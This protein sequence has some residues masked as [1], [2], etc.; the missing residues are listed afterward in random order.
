MSDPSK[1]PP[2]AVANRLERSASPYLRQH[3]F[4]P[5]EW[6]PWGD[7]A[8]AEARRLDRPIFLSIGYSTC[9][10][11]HVMARESFEQEAT[12][13]LMNRHFLS[14]KAD[15]E[16]R[17]DL[18]ELVMT[19]CQIF[20]RLVEGRPSGGW[21]L[22]AFLDPRS[23]KPFFVGTYFPPH[24]AFGRV[25]FPQL[26]EAIA[27]AWTQRRGE[28]VR[29]SEHL[30]DLIEA[31]LA[32]VPEPVE[33]PP[34]IAGEA[35][36]ALLSMEDRAHGGFG[37]A[38]KF[39]QPVHLRLLEAAARDRPALLAAIDRSLDAMALGG[40]QD[41][42]GGGFHRYCVDASWTVPHFEKMLYDNGQLAC[43][44][45]ASVRRSADPLHARALRRTLEWMERELLAPQG[46][47]F[48]AVDAEVEAREGWSYLW[49]P[50]QV[51]EALR[52]AGRADLETF[53]CAAWSL[54]EAANFQ[55]PHHPDDP[56][57]WVLRLPA[58]RPERLAARMG[59]SL[60]A[61][62]ANLDAAEAALLAARQRR[63]QPAVDDKILAGWNGLAIAG[64]AEGGAALGASGRGFIDRAIHTADAV[65]ER[66]FEGDRLLR[67]RA[68]GGDAI[69]GV[70]EDH[71]LLAAGLLALVRFG[72][73]AAQ[74][75]LEPARRILESA[76]RRFGDP[77]GG[78]FDTEADRPDL[79]L[80]ARTLDDGAVPSGT[81]TM[82]LALI[83][84]AEIAGER[85]PLERAA[86]AIRRLAGAVAASP[87]SASLSAIAAQ[88]LHAIDPALLQGPATPAQPAPVRARLDPARPTFSARGE[89]PAEVV[90]EID[91]P[92]HIN[93]H[94]PG[95]A[96]L[97]GLRLEA[98]GEGFAVE[99]SYPPGD[100]YRESIRV[101]AREV[102]VPVLL[103]RRGAAPAAIEVRLQACTDRAC[104]PPQRI[105]LEVP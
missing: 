50:Q 8:I 6:W 70:L 52:D 44:Y 97:A 61:F 33:L 59:L 91:P 54:D 19:G 25:S 60:A 82:L 4:N 45:A 26:L 73:D 37:G 14:V 24:P 79:F 32:G 55:D 41:H 78:W 102:R 62:W 56:P 104:L 31:Q 93:A 47:F 66:L 68:E 89:A 12:A 77:A 88:R 84:L 101:H 96:G 1:R 75:F 80:R 86:K 7:A 34:S 13:A 92:H 53:A 39:P 38:P 64:L 3:A 63:P 85:A 87:V 20:T 81:G 35:A 90:I 98:Q 40:L 57:A 22:S 28:V 5:V 21:P 46:G 83:D 27:E 103:R 69:D 105:R 49:T 67:V 11:C 9:Y 2:G 94:E 29:Q 65:L 72:G 58:E 17:P 100:P 99:A 36:N 76:E 95:E 30:G 48:A 42:V 18:D 74:R 51:A 15:R 10:W 23:L 43:A 71:A 16:E